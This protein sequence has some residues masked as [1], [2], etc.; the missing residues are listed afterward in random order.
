MMRIEKAKKISYKIGSM[1]ENENHREG[2]L[3]LTVC[4]QA[5]LETLAEGRAEKEEINAE[6]RV[7]I[8][9]L[10]HYASSLMIILE[11]EEKPNHD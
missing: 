5:A 2:T 7:L 10:L 3:A 9:I 4:L 6:E 1:L 11:L 8:N